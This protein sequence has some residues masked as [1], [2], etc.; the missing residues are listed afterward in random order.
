MHS[1]RLPA[2]TDIGDQVLST[3]LEALIGGW[4]GEH[5]AAIDEGARFTKNPR[6]LDGSPTDHDPGAARL[7]DGAKRVMPGAYVAV[8]QDGNAH[9][10]SSA[11]SP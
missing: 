3:Q 6:M 9:D 1:E 7:F 8:D 5:L 10:L 11:R 4:R 2:L